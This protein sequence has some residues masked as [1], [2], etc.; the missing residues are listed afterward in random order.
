MMTVVVLARTANGKLPIH[1]ICCWL[2]RS[3]SKHAAVY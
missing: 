3:G 2:W 1:Q